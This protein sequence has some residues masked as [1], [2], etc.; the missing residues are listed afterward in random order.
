MPR[1]MRSFVAAVVLLTPVVLLAQEKADKADK[2]AE[3]GPPAGAWKVYLPFLGEEG[4]GGQAR[5]LV[6]FSQKDGKWAG[7]VVSEAKG[8]PKATIEK[9]TVADKAKSASS[10]RSGNSRSPARSSR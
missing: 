6:K 7:T 1:L 3:S 5:Y 8:W 10:S 9:V 2:P 4:T